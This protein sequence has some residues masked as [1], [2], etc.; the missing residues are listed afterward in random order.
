MTVSAHFDGKVIVPDEPFDLPP[1]RELILQ[2]QAVGGK[3][4]PV[5]ESSLAWIAAN[6]V[7]RE[8]LPTDLAGRHDRYLYGR[9]S[10]GEQR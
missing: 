7:D 2:T 9:S 4:V 3:D 1:N 5:E 6:A 10:G 8:A